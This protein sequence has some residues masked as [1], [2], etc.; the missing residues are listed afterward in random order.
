M[1]LFTGISA[2]GSALRS[3]RRGRQFKSAIPETPTTKAK[4]YSF[5]FFILNFLQ[6]K[7]QARRALLIEFLV[8]KK[9][10]T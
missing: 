10:I 5:A 1:P 7:L 6:Q 3:G 4:Y 2:V 8:K 9:Y